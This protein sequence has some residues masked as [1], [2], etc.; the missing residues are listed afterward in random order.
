MFQT[1]LSASMTAMRAHRG[2]VLALA[3]AAGAL[4]PG[5][6]SAAATTAR[7]GMPWIDDDYTKA[8]AEGRARKVPIFIESWAPW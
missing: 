4:L 1:T 2:S 6:V 3:L 5:A 7:H 8:V